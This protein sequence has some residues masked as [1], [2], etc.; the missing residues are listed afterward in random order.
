MRETEGCLRLRSQQ[1]SQRRR[2]SRCN[3]KKGRGQTEGIV[4]KRSSRLGLRVAQ[5]RM[6]RLAQVRECGERGGQGMPWRGQQDWSRWRSC[7]PGHGVWVL[8]QM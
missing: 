3:L 5:C 1:G 4:D 2:K 6:N 8:A 7:E